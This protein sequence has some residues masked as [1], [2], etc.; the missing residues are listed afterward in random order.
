MLANFVTWHDWLGDISSE[1]IFESAVLV[2]GLHADGNL[3]LTENCVSFALTKTIRSTRMTIIRQC[4]DVCDRIYT[5]FVGPFQNEPIEGSKYFVTL[6]DNFACYL[7]VE[8]IN[9]M[10]AAAEAINNVVVSLRKVIWKSAKL[11]SSKTGSGV[12]HIRS[13]GGK[14]YIGKYFLN[15]IH[16]E[17]QYTRPLYLSQLS[18]VRKQRDSF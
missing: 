11:L 4:K 7:L 14:N 8:F 16:E 15:W 12:K 13:E 3:K 9:L 10:S 1:R 17:V 2:K 18:L 6:T 5:D